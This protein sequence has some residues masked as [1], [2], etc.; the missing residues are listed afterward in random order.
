MTHVLGVVVA[1]SGIPFVGDNVTF[2]DIC[3]WSHT[4]QCSV[5]N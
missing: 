1:V 5:E 3:A 2:C 4:V